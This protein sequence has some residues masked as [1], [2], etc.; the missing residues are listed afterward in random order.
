MR[1]EKI[2]AT[3][4]DPPRG[5]GSTLDYDV[6]KEHIGFAAHRAILVLMR[7]FVMQTGGIRPTTFNALVLIGANPGITQSQLA[8]ALMLDK[9]TAAHLLGYLEM[10][11]WIE[12]RTL[13]EDRRWKGVYLSPGG[14]QE[15]ARLKGEI[16][17][18]AVRFHGLYTREEHQ[19]LL[20]LLNRVVRAV[21]DGGE[22]A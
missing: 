4:D 2:I 19:Q 13:A 8:G 1:A 17:K 18:L 16:R 5:P 20:E 10:Q 3:L 9:G 12:R 6:L 21:E 15:A 14:V 22:G 7:E 11:G